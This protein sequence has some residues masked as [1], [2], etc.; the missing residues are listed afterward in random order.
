MFNQQPT[1]T[2]AKMVHLYIQN[3]TSQERKHINLSDYQA[4]VAQSWVRF[5]SGGQKVEDGG[6][7]NGNERERAVEHVFVFFYR[8]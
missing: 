8:V 2:A 6:A 5:F 1:T 4:I 3:K 7:R